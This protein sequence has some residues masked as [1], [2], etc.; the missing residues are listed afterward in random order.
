MDIQALA[1]SLLYHPDPASHALVADLAHTNSPKRIAS[2]GRR[3][4]SLKRSR[5]PRMAG[6]AAWKQSWQAHLGTLEL[7][8]KG[9]WRRGGWRRGGWR[10]GCRSEE[11]LFLCLQVVEAFLKGSYEAQ[12]QA[13]AQ[14]RALLLH[15]V[16]SVPRPPP[17]SPFLSSSTLWPPLQLRTAEKPPRV[18]LRNKMSQIAALVFVRDFPARSALWRLRCWRWE[19][20]SCRWANFFAE[21]FAGDVLTSAAVV[22]FYLRTLIAIDSEVADRDISRTKEVPFPTRPAAGAPGRQYGPL[23]EMAKSSA[24]KDDMREACI[25]SIVDSWAQ[26]LVCIPCPSAQG[27]EDE[28]PF[29]VEL[30]GGG[31]REP[32]HLLPLPSGPRCLHRLD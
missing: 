11:E 6:V 16:S 7:S 21:V 5:R 18:Y 9:R 25:P 28:S 15:F 2:S 1:G 10:S 22:D 19:V 24:L 8:L 20:G 13:Q 29:V 31:G 23:K 17:S 4:G 27:K 32:R 26:I 14:L 30:P 12:P 3:C